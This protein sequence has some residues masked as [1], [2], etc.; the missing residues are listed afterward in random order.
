M[1]VLFSASVFRHFIAFHVPYIKYF[2]SIGAE[3]YAIANDED[4]EQKNV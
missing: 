2:Q 3:V 1:K 4:Q